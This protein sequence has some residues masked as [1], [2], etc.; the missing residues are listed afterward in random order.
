MSNFPNYYDILNIST[1]V[2]EEEIYTAYR[3][4]ISQFNNLPF[5]TEK[6]IQEIKLLKQS[7]YVLGDQKKKFKYDKKY[8]KYLD[9]EEP[10]ID[11]TKISDR[12]F[13]IAKYTF[14]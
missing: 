4:K 1:N 11:N 9:S 8:T 10:N 13:S 12:I 7:I 14:K 6:M 5:L 2:S 3:N